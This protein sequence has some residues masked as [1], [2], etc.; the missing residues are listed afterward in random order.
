MWVRLRPRKR[1]LRDLQDDR[2]DLAGAVETVYVGDM[3]DRATPLVDGCR[4]L[5]RRPTRPGSTRTPEPRGYQPHTTTSEMLAQLVGCG[6]APHG[7]SMSAKP[8]ALHRVGLGESWDGRPDVSQR[9]DRNRRRFRWRSGEI[10]RI[11]AVAQP[12]CFELT[13]I[14]PSLTAQ[15]TAR[16]IGDPLDLT[17]PESARR[18]P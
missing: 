10:A 13:A 3:A 4:S 8:D 1:T 2:A 5:T 17:L 7:V 6:R 16:L 14:K 15:P 12:M 9:R 11:T 18:S